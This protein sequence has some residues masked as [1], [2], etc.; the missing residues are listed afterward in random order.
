MPRESAAERP[1]PDY[2]TRFLTAPSAGSIA[3][4]P[5]DRPAAAATRLRPRN[6]ALR[7]MLAWALA[8]PALGFAI[9]ALPWRTMP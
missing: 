5:G 1:L 6:R 9:L 4:T 3:A 7:I 8:D 2:L